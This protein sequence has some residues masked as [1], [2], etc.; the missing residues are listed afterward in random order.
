[1]WWYTHTQIQ[2]GSS[3]TIV[4]GSKGTKSGGTYTSSKP[5]YYGAAGGAS[6]LA[7]GGSGI[8]LS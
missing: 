1:M 5:S 2:A 8:D 3:T 6:A 4:N 7:Q